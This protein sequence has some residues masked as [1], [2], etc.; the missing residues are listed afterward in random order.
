V[1]VFLRW[2]VFGIIAVAALIYAY[3][4]IGHLADRRKAPP[5]AVV[6]PPAREPENTAAAAD[7]APKAETAQDEQDAIPDHCAVELDV[8]RR[9]VESHSI[10][11]PLDRLLR[12]QEIAWEKDDKRRERLTQLATRWYNAPGPVDAARLRRDVVVACVN[13]TL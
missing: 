4:A 13:A 2:G 7:A 3:N 9:A 11:E 12:I 10:G 5:A 6:A 1:G 8:A